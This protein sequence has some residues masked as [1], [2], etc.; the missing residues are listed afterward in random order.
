MRCSFDTARRVNRATHNVRR[1]A[2]SQRVFFGAG[3]SS[4]FGLAAARAPTCS[5]KVL[6]G[7]I[8]VPARRRKSDNGER[9]RA[10]GEGQVKRLHS[11]SA[12]LSE[13]WKP[14]T[15]TQR[16]TRS[17]SNSSPTVRFFAVCNA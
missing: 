8:C 16:P 3:L 15:I 10:N 6:D 14:V 5:P 4:V 13:D 17:S 7:G 12:G 9:N 1:G 11:E 2:S